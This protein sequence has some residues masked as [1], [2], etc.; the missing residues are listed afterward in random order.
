MKVAQKNTQSTASRGR[1]FGL[2]ADKV[3]EQKIA[4]LKSKLGLTSS[5]ELFR[6]AIHKLYQKEFQK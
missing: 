5:S 1:L 3:H 4:E 6:Y 2:W